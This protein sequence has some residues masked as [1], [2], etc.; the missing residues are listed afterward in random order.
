MKYYCLGLFFLLFAAD[1]MAATIDNYQFTYLQQEKRFHSLIS[2]L[3]CLV[4]QNQNLADSNA[5]LA[6]DLRN[7][8]YE[9][10]IHGQSDSEI[11]KYLIQRYGDYVL[12][13]PPM[14]KSTYILWFGPFSFLLLAFLLLLK[15]L[16]SKS[17]QA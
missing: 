14:N 3:R 12:F 17:T 5:P 11:K 6:K 13:K 8:V 9:Q 2:E 16:K 15:N 7:E 10:I 4:C 1:V